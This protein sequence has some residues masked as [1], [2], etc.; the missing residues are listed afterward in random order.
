MSLSTPERSRLRQL[1]EEYAQAL[2]N[3]RLAEREAIAKRI[4]Y[5]DYVQQLGDAGQEKEAA[6]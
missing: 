1:A 2:G 3:L 6:P 5:L 4:A